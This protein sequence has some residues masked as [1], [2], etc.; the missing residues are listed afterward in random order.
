MLDGNV[1][2]SKSIDLG[3]LA[4][5]IIGRSFDAVHQFS[6]NLQFGMGALE[7]TFDLLHRAIQWLN[8]G[9]GQKL[10]TYTIILC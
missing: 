4:T 6:A 7:F 9:A 3:E 2:A 8:F 10:V 5:G 1:C